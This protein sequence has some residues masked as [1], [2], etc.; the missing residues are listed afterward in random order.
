MNTD[1]TESHHPKVLPFLFLTEM[2]E[3]FGFYLVQGL[4]VLY[5]TQF[6][7]FSD[8]SSFAIS[9]VFVGLSAKRNELAR[10]HADDMPQDGLRRKT[11]APSDTSSAR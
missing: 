1:A 11:I 2:W 3:R 7:G 9:G 4:L 8:D 6:Y 10:S 5:L